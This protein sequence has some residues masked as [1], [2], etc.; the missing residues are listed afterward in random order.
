MTG[1]P[2][3]TPESTPLYKPHPANVPGQFYVMDGCCLG[4]ALP[5]TEAPDLFGWFEGE[6]SHCYVKKQPETKA[7]FERMLQAMSVQ[8]AACVRAKF[9]DPEFFK[10]LKAAG[11]EDQVDQKPKAAR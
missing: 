11:E 10:R 7:E 5:E 9:C 3:S 6:W 8:E 2:A 1:T 4:C